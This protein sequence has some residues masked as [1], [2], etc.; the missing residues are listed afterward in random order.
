MASSFDTFSNDGEEASR[1]SS[2]PFDD[3]GYTGYDSQRYESYS[4][5]SL[6]EEGKESAVAGDYIHGGGFGNDGIGVGS[7]P[8]SPEP[9]GFVSDPH[10]E[11]SGTSPFSMP[12]SNGHAYGARENGG[13]FES[14]GPVLPDLGEMQPE[15]GF[16][17]REWRRQNAIHLEEKEKRE[18]EIRN[19]IIAEAEEYKRAF[20]E[21]R[22]LNRETNI[23]NNREKQKLFL[24]NQEK[25]HA[26]ADKQYWK[27]I[28]DL[29][30]NEV[31]N[32]EKRGKKDQ[33]K[34]PSI[35][36]IQGPK[37]GKPADLSRMRHLLMKLK[38]S[39]PPHMKPPPPPAKEP[40]KD[41]DAATKNDGKKAPSP[42]KEATLS[43][44]P[45][46]SPQKLSPHASTAVKEPAA[47]EPEP[48]ST[49]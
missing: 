20:Y 46:V 11:Y 1:V 9:Y 42:T 29:I 34:K 28:S 33:E 47:R 35:V 8:A 15:E 5:F 37:P 21:K 36:V 27:A 39:P 12:E 30:P 14:D 19:Q 6:D 32:I 49:Q 16:L 31:P 38:H 43:D 44:K 10:P 26:E 45:P 40:A 18:K 3:D 4:N 7:T 17:L 25:F 2:R 13:V 48:T 23:S 41:G 24:A 22:Q